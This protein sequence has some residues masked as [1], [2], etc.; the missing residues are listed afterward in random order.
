MARPDLKILFKSKT[1]GKSTEV[2]AC[3]KNDF[4]GFNCKLV[5]EESKWATPLLAQFAADY[6]VNIVPVTNK[7]T[8]DD[9]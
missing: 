7:A 5:T 2:A 1:T 3:W 9:L 8:E 4:S 6:Y